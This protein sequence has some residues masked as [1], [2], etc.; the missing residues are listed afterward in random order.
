MVSCVQCGAGADALLEDDG[1]LV[2]MDCGAVVGGLLSNE[3]AFGEH[4]AANMPSYH[5]QQRLDGGAFDWRR[6]EARIR[7]MCEQLH[8]DAESTATAQQLT[9][10]VLGQPRSG[11]PL[12]ATAACCVLLTTRRDTA[13]STFTLREVSLLAQCP[14]QAIGARWMR[15]ML[16][17][18]Q[19]RRQQLCGTADQ[20]GAADG[21]AG[22]AAGAESADTVAAAA[23]RAKA[24]HPEDCHVPS[25]STT[26]LPPLPC[27]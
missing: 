9:K 14:A 6:V 20:G 27:T 3:V 12:E 13:G 1:Q 26:C 5:S 2:C 10:V 16:Q 22:G 7:T 15:L 18:Q 21:A 4:T 17:I 8:M 24:S 25:I 19:E 11:V 23:Q